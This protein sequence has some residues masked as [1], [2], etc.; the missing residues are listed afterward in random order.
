MIQ[1]RS[2]SKT[3]RPASCLLTQRFPASDKW[4][5]SRISEYKSSSMKTFLLESAFGRTH[6]IV[7]IVLQLGAFKVGRAIYFCCWNKRP[8]W[9]GL[10]IDSSMKHND[11]Q[12][13]NVR[14]ATNQGSKYCLSCAA[15]FGVGTNTPHICADRKIRQGLG[16][17]KCV[18]PL[19]GIEERGTIKDMGH[20]RHRGCP[21]LG[22]LEEWLGFYEWAVDIHFVCTCSLENYSCTNRGQFVGMTTII[23]SQSLYFTLFASQGENCAERQSTCN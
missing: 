15:H 10:K 16:S 4:S 7:A 13:W 11:S 5:S 20:F 8:M 1:S 18:F 22:I 23:N 14:H 3:T 9:K 12:Q 17:T 19:A 2:L 21:A 6:E